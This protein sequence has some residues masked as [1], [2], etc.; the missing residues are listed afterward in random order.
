MIKKAPLILMLILLF[1]CGQIEKYGKPKPTVVNQTTDV[2]INDTSTNITNSTNTTQEAILLPDREKLNV[3]P[4][5]SIEGN[6]V[7]IILRNT[8]ILINSGKEK[9]SGIIIKQLRDFGVYKLDLVILQNGNEENVGGLPYILLRT[10]PTE[11][12]DNGIP[13]LWAKAYRNSKQNT[14]TIIKDKIEFYNGIYIRYIVPYDDGS[15]IRDKENA[16]TIVLKASYGNFDMLLMGDCDYDCEERMLSS[17]IASDFVYLS[18]DCSATSLSYLGKINPEE[19]YLI[20]DCPDVKKRLDY[21]NYPRRDKIN[22]IHS[23]GV[24]FEVQ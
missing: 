17:D 19:V 15:G 18:N 1:G 14:T 22:V 20:K 24:G 23:D 11:V 13:T 8:S 5:N 4:I 6:A 10:Q 16:N 7:V 2:K 21:L 12:I 9:D 3:F